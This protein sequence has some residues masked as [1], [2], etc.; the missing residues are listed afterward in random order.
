MRFN[1]SNIEIYEEAPIKFK[2]TKI[3]QITK[4]IFKNDLSSKFKPHNENL[5]PYLIKEANR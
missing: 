5:K 3:L 4:N 1:F 2:K